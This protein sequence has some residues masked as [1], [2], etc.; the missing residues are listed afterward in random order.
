M[1]LFTSDVVRVAICWVPISLC[2]HHVTKVFTCFCFCFCLFWWCF[3][4]VLVY[5]PLRERALIQLIFHQLLILSRSKRPY[6]NHYS[7]LLTQNV[8]A[9]TLLWW[10]QGSDFLQSSGWQDQDRGHLMALQV[11]LGAVYGQTWVLLYPNKDKTRPSD[12]FLL[13]EERS[14]LEECQRHY[15]PS[16]KAQ[17]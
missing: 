10:N 9:E 7:D 15:W 16:L 12:L 3:A 6:A 1:I 11:S 17:S 2:L 4:V 13:H 8:A 5:V 14:W